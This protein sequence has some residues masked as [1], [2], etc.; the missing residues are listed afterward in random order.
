MSNLPHCV[1][2][3]TNKQKSGNKSFTSFQ[4]KASQAL[5]MP[6]ICEDYLD[7]STIKL[8]VSFEQKCVSVK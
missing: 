1:P 5:F 4:I 6:H 3:A 2:C 8:S 7:P